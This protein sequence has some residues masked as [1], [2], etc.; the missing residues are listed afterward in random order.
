MYLGRIIEQGSA[1]RVF[2]EP[3]HPYTQ[4]LLASV[5]RLGGGVLPSAT[6]SEP[7][8]PAALPSGCP[9]H[10]RCRHAEPPCRTGDPP[11]LVQ[12]LACP[13]A[14]RSTTD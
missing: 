6:Q 10:P 1:E 2:S 5:P 9:F 3:R 7:P 13:P 14:A 8:N 11:P 12:G 4:A